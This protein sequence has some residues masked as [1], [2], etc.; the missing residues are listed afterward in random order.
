[1]KALVKTGFGPGKL[2]IREVE[3]PKIS[4]KEVLIEVRACAICGSDVERYV[5]G[6]VE[7]KPP[8]VLGHEISGIIAD[9]GENVE[10]FEVGN[11]VSVE[12]NLNACGKCSF[13]RAGKENLCLSRIG[14]GYDIDGG[15]A[16]YVKVPANMLIPL[17]QNVSFEEGALMDV[18]VALHSVI[19]RAQINQGDFTLIFGPGFLGLCILQICK[20]YSDTRVIVIGTEKDSLR[21]EVAKR[22]GAND[23]LLF[24]EDEIA[25]KVSKMTA[26]TGADVIFQVSESSAATN[27]TLKL[28]RRGG[29]IIMIGIIPQKIEINLLSATLK[30][31]SMIGVRAYTWQNCI[32]AMR[33]ISEGKISLRQF[34]THKFPLEDWKKAFE[35]LLKGEAIK[36]V[37]IP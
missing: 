30:E 4:S 1:M 7:Y 16:E 29:K 20:L 8:V 25:R 26:G 3:K 35:I 22:L 14:I 27:L 31:V 32:S 19:D 12:A 23:V 17:P 2:E 18:C 33:L 15:F 9:K 36:I 37:L 11:R 13:C 28:I 21:L 5:G 10:D 6:N 34:M 24:N